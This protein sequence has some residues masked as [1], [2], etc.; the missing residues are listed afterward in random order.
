METEAKTGLKIIINDRELKANGDETILEL[1]KNNN[2]YIP[3]L[4]HHSDLCLKG[5]CRIC[6]VEIEGQNILH[7]ACS[8]PVAENMIICTNTEKVRKARKMVIELLLANHYGDCLTCKRNL[9]CELQKLAAEYNIE[10][11]R[12]KKPKEK[13]YKIETVTPIVRDNDKCILCRRCIRVC[14]KIQGVEAIKPLYRG[15]ESSIGCLYNLDLGEITCVMCGQCINHCPTGA[16][17]EKDATKDAWKALDNPAKH[18]I[19]Q[20]APSIRVAL[21]EEFNI[22][23]G[24]AVTGKM[25]AA[26]REIGFNAIFDTDFTADLLIVEESFEFLTKLKKSYYDNENISLP[27]FTSCCPSWI[28]FIEHYYPDLLSHLSTCKSPQQMFGALAK[29]YYANKAGISPEDMVSISI[30][31]CTA[32]KFE[33]N[34]AEMSHNGYKNVDYVLTTREF[35]RMIKQSGLN[36]MELQDSEYDQSMGISTGAGLIFGATGGVTEGILRTVYELVTGNDVP[37]NELDITPARGMEGIREISI[38][39][40]NPLENWKFL[41]DFE[42]KIAVAHGL[43]NA[44]NLMD[45]IRDGTANYH[46]IEIMACPGGCI[47]GG[48]QPIPTNE[49]IR[50]S[51]ANTIY[52]EEKIVQ[53][54]KSHENP[55][56]KRLYEEFLE[57]PLGETS[58]KLLHTFYT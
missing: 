15:K 31:P 5:V 9:N 44:R 27:M 25:I 16:L 49:S 1:A 55:A 17:T 8:T 35:A 54:R 4:C 52:S 11:I 45:K 18:V 37:F 42:I 47:G 50:K 24:I 57:N 40:N 29:T 33:A 39:I 7:A 20:T 23:P 34:R 43:A 30:M 12:F 28:N 41:D 14:E 13:R 51:R 46:F 53:I 2:I 19:V 56:L 58:K 6:L 32:K 3:T 10:E 48:G 21:A 26:L 36:L 22:P 38:K